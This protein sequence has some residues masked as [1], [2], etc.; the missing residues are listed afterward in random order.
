MKMMKSL[1]LTLCL[2]LSVSAVTSKKAEAGLLLSPVTAGGSMALSIVGQGV[3]Y[4]ATGARF[5]GLIGYR[6]MARLWGAGLLL[7]GLDDDVAETANN[8]Q[9]VLS[10][11]Y[12]MIADQTVFAD[13]AELVMNSENVDEY[14]HG[15]LDVKLE[16]SELRS[17]L[18]R[19]D[20]TD[21]ESDLE[22]LVN[23]LI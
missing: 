23:D 7:V 22:N 14:N 12:P 11:R 20:S 2:T 21:I 17:T 18:E 1:V 6:D 19:L 16:E 3:L 10:S 15:V 5:L 13:I 4:G 8:I 9:E